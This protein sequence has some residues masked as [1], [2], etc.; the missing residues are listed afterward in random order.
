VDAASLVA[1]LAAAP[2]RAAV[3]FDLDGTLA[4]I[5]ARPELA[6]VP[7]ATRSELA[8]LV[9]RY[10]L[11]GCVSGRPAPEAAH[12]LEVDGVETVGNHGLE[13]HPDGDRLAEAIA[14]FRRRIADRWPV[15]D[16]GLSLSLHYRDVPDER[17]ALQLLEPIAREALAAGLVPRWGRKVLEIRP[18]AEVDKATAVRALL[19]RSHVRLGLYA[20]D[21]TTDL[22]AFR[23][24]RE[25]ELE[26]AV[27]VAVASA[28]ADPSLAAAADAV[29]DGPAGLLSLMRLL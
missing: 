21:D 1:P 26:H 23:G 2:D 12:L 28:E 9:L 27:A 19:E 15:E 10:R 4:P 11:V 13:L 16:K 29:V 3:L 8:R 24:L 25:A 22:D 20:G 5:V 7:A 18:D 6:S 17:A 14:S